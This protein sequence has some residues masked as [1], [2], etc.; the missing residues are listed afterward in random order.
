MKNSMTSQDW[1]SRESIRESM[2]GSW[3]LTA[4]LP[5]VLV[6]M[7]LLG[8]EYYDIGDAVDGSGNGNGHSGGKKGCE[9]GGVHYR[10]GASF[11]SSDGCNQ[12]SCQR[13]GTVVCTLRA[14]AAVCGGLAG[15]PCPEGQYCNFPPEAQCGAADQTGV[16]A[17]R[18]EACTREFAPVCGCDDAT[19]SNACVA[20]AAGVS[21]ASQGECGSGA[22]QIGDACG[23]FRPSDAPNCDTGLFCQHQPGA[24]CGAADAPGECVAIPEVCADIFDPVC[25]CDGQTYSNACEAAANQVGILARGECQ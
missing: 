17:V 18:P 11:P 25:G 24:L 20:A 8:C 2:R 21:V 16:C 5:A 1:S 23:G 4:W 13:D 9:Y 7:P 19:Y 12:C 3:L 22:L 15:T 6:A 14:C 10:P